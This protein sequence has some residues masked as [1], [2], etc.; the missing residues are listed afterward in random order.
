LRGRWTLTRPLVGVGL[1]VAERVRC[2]LAGRD[3]LGVLLRDQALDAIGEQRNGPL[4]V[5]V[6]ARTGEVEVLLMLERLG[7]RP[8][9]APVLLVL[10][11]LLEALEDDDKRA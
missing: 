7:G 9:G 5:P 3:P 10:V 6:R 11:Q 4:R 2:L 8:E 1:A